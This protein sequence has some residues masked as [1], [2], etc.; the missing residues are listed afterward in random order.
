[1]KKEFHNAVTRSD[2]DRF[3]VE[4]VEFVSHPFLLCCSAEREVTPNSNHSIA[5]V[6]FTNCTGSPHGS[7]TMAS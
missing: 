3:C 6:R 2:A 7:R 4:T 5:L 1:M